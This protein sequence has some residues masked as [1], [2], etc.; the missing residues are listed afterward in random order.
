MYL[1][2]KSNTLH[3]IEDDTKINTKRKTPLQT[4]NYEEMNHSRTKYHK[5]RQNN[6]LNTDKGK[7][8]NFNITFASIILLKKVKYSGLN[9]M[10]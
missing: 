2:T 1:E 6:V 4:L 7:H 9:K 10:K 3:N 5:R 8:V